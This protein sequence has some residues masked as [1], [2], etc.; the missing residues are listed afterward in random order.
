MT[1]FVITTEN[2][3]EVFPSALAAGDIGQ[4]ISFTNQDELGKSTADW[5][6]TLLVEIHNEAAGAPP[7]GDLKPVKKFEN[8]QIAVARLWNMARKL[9]NGSGV[10]QESATAGAPV[11][12]A[13]PPAGPTTDDA[14]PV[15]EAAGAPAAAKGAKKT[16]TPAK[17]KAP[18]KEPKAPKAPKAPKPGREPKAKADRTPR[19]GTK[20]ARAIEMLKRENGASNEELQ[21]E[22]GWAPHT[23]RG[24]IAGAL[25]TKMGIE[26][27]SFKTEAGERRY[28][29]A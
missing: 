7:F 27:E 12:H 10:G 5:P 4:G 29:I 24:F 18:A 21:G 14:T 1:T 8:R 17:Q 22:F 16:K 23:V 13:A 9:A 28:R 3:I 20:Q 19:T 11:A 15:Q 26:V 25:K 6:L 2:A